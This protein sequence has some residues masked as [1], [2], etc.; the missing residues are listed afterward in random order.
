MDDFIEV[1]PNALDPDACRQMVAR[2]EASGHA[3][4]GRTGG[5]VDTALKDSFDIPVST[6]PDW[7]DVTA[8]L[9]RVAALGL[10]EYV[11]KYPFLLIGPL[12]L[13]VP[14]PDGRPLLVDAD[15][16]PRLPADQYH[17]LLGRAF[18]PGTINL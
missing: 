1:Y 12:G 18:R 17:A 3:V 11:R 14:G 7:Q 10:R 5:G 15:T 6:R 8:T 16:F 2:F 9:N 13:R 4:R